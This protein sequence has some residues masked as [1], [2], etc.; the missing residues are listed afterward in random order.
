MTN[1]HF[2]HKEDLIKILDECLGKTLGEVDKNNVF[3]RTIE[4]PKITGIAGDVIEQSVLGYPSDNRQEP[5]LN[6]DGVKTEL[7]T[8][9]IKYIRKYTQLVAKEPM[10]ITA[11]SPDQIVNEEFDDSN[12]WHKLSH[13]LFVYYLYDSPTTVNAAG[14]AN[15]PIKGYQFLEFDSEDKDALKM[16]WTIVRDFIIYLQENYENYENEYPRISSELRKKLVLIDTAPKW[17]NRPRFR[18][19]KNYLSLIVQKHF[20]ETLEQLPGA[21]TSYSQIDS[22]C[23]NL[24]NQYKGKSVRELLNI[25]DIPIGRT[26]NKSIGE[27]IIV[28][29]FGG[30]SK[31]MQKIE[32]FVKFGII[33]KTITLTEN[34][35]RKEDMKFF[36][37]DFE[38]FYDDIEFECSQFY[39]YFSN[40]QFLC[41]IFQRP[42]NDADFLEYEFLGFKKISFD[43]E[44]I[45]CEVKECWD[46]IKDKILNDKLKDVIDL[47]KDGN[48]RMNR[49]GVVRSAPNFPKS[50]DFTIFV[51]GS[52]IDSGV[53]PLQLNGI[54]MYNQYCWIKGTYMVE[55]LEKTE[56]I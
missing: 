20:G 37:I 41:I 2:F 4:H 56:F 28:K 48:P 6:I 13:L 1:A 24:T 54:S 44:F 19:K 23:H 16:D 29:M 3:D 17:P 40:N 31:K 21:Y 49:N 39:D 7:K 47:D 35:M 12:F 5:D 53:K 22:F 45:E 51:R 52:G 15:F 50:K 38:E 33:G 9:G 25:F 34:G 14:Y 27:Q 10:S 30:Q 8:T 18:L 55:K 36:N 26:I 11:V 42:E 43:E 46:D 32:L